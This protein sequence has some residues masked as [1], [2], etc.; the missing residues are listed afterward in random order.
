MPAPYDSKKMVPPKAPELNGGLYTG[1]PFAGAWGNV[2][3]LP[4]VT[5]LT[6]KTLLMQDHEP[7]GALATQQYDPGLLRPGNNAPLSVQM[8]MYS[9]NVNFA[10]TTFPAEKKLVAPPRS[11][12]PSHHVVGASWSS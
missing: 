2:P 5:P 7:M 9:S 6:T 3:V 12:D 10:C 11:F 1:E 4:D 8:A